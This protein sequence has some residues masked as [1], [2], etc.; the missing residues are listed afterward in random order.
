MQEKQF[1][2]LI[3]EKALD[4][5][6]PGY[7]VISIRKLK[8]AVRDATLRMAD[9][10]E[11]QDIFVEGSNLINE[12]LLKVKLNNLIAPLHQSEYR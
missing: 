12:D 2:E 8:N 5:L 9:E 10:L 11:I 4:I 3:E 6:K 7:P 1:I